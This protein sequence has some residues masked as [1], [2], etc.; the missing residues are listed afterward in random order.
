[1]SIGIY[2]VNNLFTIERVSVC[3]GGCVWIIDRWMDGMS[4]WGCEQDGVWD[5]GC[6]GLIGVGRVMQVGG[7]N[8]EFGWVRLG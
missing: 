7:E 6:V 3:V 2:K 8:V 4:E 5:W 1:M